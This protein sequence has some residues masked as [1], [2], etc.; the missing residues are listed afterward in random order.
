LGLERVSRLQITEFIERG[1]SSHGVRSM[2]S[3]L[4]LLLKRRLQMVR[5]LLIIIA[6]VND[7]EGSSGSW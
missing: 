4:G 3:D 5:I 6:D 7:S 1:G 2:C